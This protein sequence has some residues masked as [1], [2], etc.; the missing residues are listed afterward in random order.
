MLPPLKGI[1]Y[2]AYSH[3]HY[4]LLAQIF[5]LRISRTL[6]PHASYLQIKAV[7]NL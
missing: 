1:S 5:I 6:N 2:T 4:F 3:M 7:L